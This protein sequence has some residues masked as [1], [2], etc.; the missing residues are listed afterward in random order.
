MHFCYSCNH[1]WNLNTLA[2]FTLAH[3]FIL[4]LHER[5]RVAKRR[6]KTRKRREEERERMEEERQRDRGVGREVEKRDRRGEEK[7]ERIR[8]NERNGRLG[9]EG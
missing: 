6:G 4:I 2:P 3:S 5:R 7:R 8:G 9:E 1:Y